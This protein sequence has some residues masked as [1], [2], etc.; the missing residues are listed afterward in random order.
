MTRLGFAGLGALGEALIREVSGV[1]GLEV[2]AA[3]DVRLDLARDIAARYEVSWYGECFEDLLAA[4]GVEA[5]VICT[6]NAFHASQAQ[7]ALRAGKDVLVQGAKTAHPWSFVP[8]FSKAVDAFNNAMTGAE[9]GDGS[10]D[11]VISRT[12]AVIDQQLSGP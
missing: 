6:P 4:D 1:R 2:V 7:A 10:A 3:Q 8:G 9:Q 5:V 11:P 12:K